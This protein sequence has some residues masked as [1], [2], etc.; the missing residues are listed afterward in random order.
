MII[1]Y[2][3]EPLKQFQQKQETITRQAP[4]PRANIE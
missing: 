2:K 1:I 4:R 3:L